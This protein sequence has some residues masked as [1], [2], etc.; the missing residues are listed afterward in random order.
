[1]K[2]ISII[3]LMIFFVLSSC[4]NNTAKKSANSGELTII[5]MNDTH[6]RDEEE[7]IVNK[8]TTPPETNY[9]YG[10]ARRATYIKDV[11][12][13]NNNVLVLHAGDTITGS[14]Y[15]TVFLGRDE[16]D[17]MNMIGVDAA[18][19]GNHFVDYG[20]DNFTEIMK[21]RKFPT[22][23][24]NIKNKNDNSYYAL[25][26]IVTNV[27]GLNVAIIGITTTESV[28]SA[29][30]I[31]DIVFEKEIDSLKSFLKSTPLNTTND[32]TILLSHVGYE[33]DKKIAEAFP[34]TFDVI[35]GGHSHTVLEKADI[36]NGTPI[37]QAGSYGMYLG[38]ID[39]SVNNGKIEK[40]DYKLIPMD[41]NIKQDADMLAFI[42]EM[43]GTVDK[44][45]N[46]KIG[47]LPVELTQ[48]GIRT[49]SMALGNF[50][51]DL[52]LDS[53]DNVDIAIINSGALR[54]SLPYGDITLGKIQNEFFP[55]NNQAVIVTLNG[56][57]LL[58]MI[59]ISYTK[60]GS[61]GFLQYSRGVEVKYSTDGKLISAKLNG[62]D[63]TENKDYVIII[64]DF[65]L[66]GGDGYQDA[67][68]SPIGKKGKNIVMT[69]NDMRDAII[70]KIKELNNIPESYIDNNPRVIF[71]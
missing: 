57:D 33:V 43:K 54:T 18:A 51:C 10:A 31:K 50:A 64:S 32:V 11:K 45:F 24:V 25:P 41:G 26:Y 63:I 27:N 38:H 14:V 68:G 49:N 13:T 19:I 8:E 16:V 15:S 1:M 37:V 6:G 46:V 39:L 5:H 48:D 23:S 58:D 67:D 55:F 53:Y 40:I 70:S 12:S 20:L 22:L 62:E 17:I 69:G 29:S 21:E 35:I 59:K 52:V 60:K 9:M 4:N 44:E 47:S 71:E 56:K 34:K 3:L 66:D 65:I 30:S 2:K 28:Y 42:D 36:V 61:G 7:M